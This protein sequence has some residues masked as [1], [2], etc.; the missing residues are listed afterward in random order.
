MTAGGQSG[1][2]ATASSSAEHSGSSIGHGR[3]ED[4]CVAST[5]WVECSTIRSSGDVWEWS[6][7]RASHADIEV[8]AEAKIAGG[9]QQRKRA[10]QTSSVGTHQRCQL[11]PLVA[12]VDDPAWLARQTLLV[13]LYF[14]TDIDADVH[15]MPKTDRKTLRT[16]MNMYAGHAEVSLAPIFSA[17]CAA[18][19]G[20]S[21][22]FG[23]G[24]SARARPAAGSG[25]EA[26]AKDELQPKAG[27]VEAAVVRDA[28]VETEMGAE[29]H[30]GD[31]SE[32]AVIQ[33]HPVSLCVPLVQGERTVGSVRIRVSARA[34]DR[35]R[36]HEA[37]LQ[38]GTALVQWRRHAEGLA[39]LA[40]AKAQERDED[41][42]S[43]NESEAG[44]SVVAT[45][46]HATTAQRRR[47]QWQAALEC[48]AATGAAAVLRQV[49]EGMRYEQ[50]REREQEEG[51]Q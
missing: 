40:R 27:V 11:P 1:A 8:V 24:A 23:L 45:P 21:T 16:G 38:A 2:G 15:E 47:E 12:V 25:V 39:E 49:H 3:D 34:V 43:S 37:V 51:K 22:Q 41:V 33:S 14:N 17:V 26:Q 7:D 6:G 4:G 42:Q 48:V 50:E 36:Q 28:D 19:A 35:Q 31:P 13:G 20:A 5:P 46:M 44:A 18:G 9:R 29:S 32:G 30:T 10:E